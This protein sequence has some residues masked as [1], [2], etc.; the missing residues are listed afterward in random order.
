MRR[1]KPFTPTPAPAII[2]EAMSAT[3]PASP[4][5]PSTPAATPVWLMP[6]VVASALFM[7]NF[8]SA[9]ISTSL[10]AIARDL[11]LDPVVL[12]LALTS[13]LL[14]LAIFIPVSGWLA[15]RWGPRP[16]FQAAI[17]VF[18][19]ASL[20]CATAHSLE[21]LIVARAVQG[22][23]GAM[24]VPVGRLIVLRSVPKANMV[25]ALAY[26]SIP[27][28]MAPMIGPPIG[29][30]VTTY[31]D[32]RWIFWINLP[33]G[34]LGLA[35][36]QRYM[37][38]IRAEAPRRMDWR[39]FA[40]AGPGVGALIS[41]LTLAGT[42][43]VPLWFAQALIAAGF[44]LLVLY[45]RHA[46]RVPEPLLDLRLLKLPTFR[47]SVVGGG[48]FRLGTGAIPF[49]LPL[50]LQVGF[51]LTPFQSGMITFSGALGALLMKFAARP[52]LRRFGFRQVLTF[53]ALICAAM[54]GLYALFTPETPHIVIG[55]VLL[56]GGF[57]RS[58]Q[59]TC[60]NAS[61]FADVDEKSMSGATAMVAVAQQL[62]LSTGVAMAAFILETLRAAGDSGQLTAGD[63]SVAFL[64]VAGLTGLAA[65]MHGRLPRDAGRA[66]SGHGS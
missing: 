33:I 47:T 7:E 30:F 28:L 29:G 58:L 24:M 49:L 16:V 34:M 65:I 37:P 51:G 43:V 4:G 19:A 20:A 52:L 36:A 39:G 56:A 50:M 26:L 11:S 53:N 12:K 64:V 22:I 6:M 60:L 8:D 9:V 5:P 45:I 21:H 57:F 46:L 23:G 27:A 31:F 38:N 25:D 1:G 42:D 18:I 41:G 15:D 59:F 55:L 54:L 13:Y 62:F 63:F 48:L 61:A 17:T 40:L 10:P 3:S 35:L 66:V 44:A 14:S 32:W 2:A